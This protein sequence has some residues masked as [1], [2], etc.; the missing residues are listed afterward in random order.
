MSGYHSSLTEQQHRAIQNVITSS[1]LLPADRLAREERHLALIAAADWGRLAQEGNQHPAFSA[2]C[3]SRVRR[4]IGRILIT[5]GHRF[6]AK[7][8]P[9]S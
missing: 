8:G 4:G 7:V 2:R 3:S 1:G 6:E 9:I 5:I